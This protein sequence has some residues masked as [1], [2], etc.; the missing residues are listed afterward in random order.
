[1]LLVELYD[2]FEGTLY[3]TVEF[4]SI[5]GVLDFMDESGCFTDEDMNDVLDWW[6]FSDELVY[7]GQNFSI[8]VIDD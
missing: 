8:I 5:E 1:M 6:D 7:A 2:P 3:N 4:E